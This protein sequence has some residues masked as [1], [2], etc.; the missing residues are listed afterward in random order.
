MLDAKCLHVRI[1]SPIAQK[2]HNTIIVTMIFH[3]MQIGN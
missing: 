2:G 3:F 1:I